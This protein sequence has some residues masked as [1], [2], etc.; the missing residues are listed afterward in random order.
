MR[1]TT[2]Y[3]DIIICGTLFCVTI[4]AFSYRFGHIVARFWRQLHHQMIAKHVHL[5]LPADVLQGVHA[6]AGAVSRQVVA[7]GGVV[8]MQVAR[9]VEGAG[10]PH[11]E[12]FRRILRHGASEGFRSSHVEFAA[13]VALVEGFACLWNLYF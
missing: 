11:V 5:P 7:L 4:K 8:F 6:A 10:P 13:V 3:H 9:R 12:V 2:K 1:E